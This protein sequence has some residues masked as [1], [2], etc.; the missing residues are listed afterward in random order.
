MEYTSLRGV[1]ST[2]RPLAI[3]PIEERR[4][5]L[6]DRQT[7]SRAEV[8]EKYNIDNAVISHL[9]FHYEKELTEGVDSPKKRIQDLARQGLNSAQVAERTGLPLHIV[10]KHW[11]ITIV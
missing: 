8:R 4:A 10:N 7:M 9:H 1:K 11:R 5:I 3:I 2:T 6:I